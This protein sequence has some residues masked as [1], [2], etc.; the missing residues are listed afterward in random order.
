VCFV[1]IKISQGN[2]LESTADLMNVFLMFVST[3]RGIWRRG[4]GVI[5][6]EKNDSSEVF[7]LFFFPVFGCFHRKLWSD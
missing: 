1:I 7:V 4:K 6:K 3:G 2:L 5:E